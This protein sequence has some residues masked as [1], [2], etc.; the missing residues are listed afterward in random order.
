MRRLI[1]DA[2]SADGKS[3]PAMRRRQGLVI[4][5]LRSAKVTCLSFRSMTR[6]SFVRLTFCIICP[7]TNKICSSAAWRPPPGTVRSSSSAQA[8]VGA[9]GG[10]GSPSLRSCGPGRPDGSA[11]GGS[12]FHDFRI[13]WRNL[14][15]GNVWQGR[16]PSGEKRP[17]A[18]TGCKSAREIESGGGHEC[19]DD[20][21]DHKHCEERL[22]DQAGL[23]DDIEQDEFHEPTRIHE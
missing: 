2:I 23:Q 9:A 16:T 15:G 6:E 11:A 10:H 7:R 17:S 5:I 13:W 3:A 18:A 20:G 21:H 8:C 14:K 4:P 22:A 1:V 12:T 19:G